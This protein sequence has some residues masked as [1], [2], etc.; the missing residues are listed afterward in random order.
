MRLS[1]RAA[2]LAA[3]AAALWLAGCATPPVADAGLHWTSGRLSLRVDASGEQAAR[4]LEAGFDLRGDGEQGELRLATPLGMQLA[5][6]RWTRDEAVL[7]LG[8]G[9]SR[10]PSLESLSRAALGETLPLRALPDW[11][12][13]RPWPGAAAQPSAEGFEQL[14]WQISLAGWAHGRVEALRE[15]P[16]RVLVRVRLAPAG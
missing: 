10:Y 4:S 16:P 5:R 8:R 13:G 14:G 12:A 1:M 3:G 9:E 15:Q 2:A 11:L 6:A 7:D